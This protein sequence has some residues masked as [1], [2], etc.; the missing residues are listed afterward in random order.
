FTGGSDGGEPYGDLIFSGN[1]LYGTTSQ[2]G[3]SGLG[4]VFKLN[5][6]DTN[7]TTLYSFTAEIYGTNTD[8]AG[9]HAGVVLSGETL[10]GTAAGG[11]SAGE[12]TVFK[13]NT[14]GTGFT[15]LHNFTATSG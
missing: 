3:G 5:L 12:G 14:D 10:Y 13:I 4:T 9:P 1:V 7:F 11:G 15:N 6:D 8:G 2:N